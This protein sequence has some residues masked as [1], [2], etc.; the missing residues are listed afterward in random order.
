MTVLYNEFSRIKEKY[1]HYDIVAESVIY[2]PVINSSQ[3][4][5]VFI[6]NSSA[7]SRRL[8]EGGLFIQFWRVGVY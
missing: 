4:T 2:K 8:F 3:L 6:C 5:D 1:Q 7:A